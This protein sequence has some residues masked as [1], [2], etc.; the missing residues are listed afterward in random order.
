MRNKNTNIAELWSRTCHQDD[1]KAFE[2]LFYAL[3]KP[4][5]KF[6]VLYVKQNEVAE[7]IVSEL[8]VKCWESR[9]KL[10]GILNPATYLYIAVKNQSLNYVKKYSNIHMVQIEDTDEFALVNTYNPQKE[11]EKKELVFKLDKAIASLPQQCRII[12]RLIKEDGMRYKEVAEVLDI[13]PRTVQT[14]LF[15][16]LK[17]LTAVLD[18]DQRRIP[19]SATDKTIFGIISILLSLPLFF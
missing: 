5:I 18:P 8:F 13:S 7:D 6:C 1:M 10:T 14:Q 19:Q 4:L 15:R 3:N 16:A 9:K 2:Q 17:K 11:L 12:F